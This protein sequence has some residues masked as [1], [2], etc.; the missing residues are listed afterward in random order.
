[1]FHG[2]RASTLHVFKD[3]IRMFSKMFHHSL[4]IGPELTVREGSGY[5]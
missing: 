3:E 5:L 2:L 1:M 4:Q